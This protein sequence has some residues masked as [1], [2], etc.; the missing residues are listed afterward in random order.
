M[1]EAKDYTEHWN[2]EMNMVYVEASKKILPIIFPTEHQ[3]CIDSA[4]N[5][6]NISIESIFCGV[7]WVKNTTS[8]KK[9]IK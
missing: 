9:K 6:G 7:W 4:L 3:N 1:Q 8:R 2:H 5:P